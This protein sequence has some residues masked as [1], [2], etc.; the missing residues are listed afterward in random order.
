VQ[1]QLQ[2]AQTLVGLPL[3]QPHEL[4]RAGIRPA[5]LISALPGARHIFD[6]SNGALPCTA[7]DNYSRPA[8]FSALTTDA[9]P[10]R[11]RPSSVKSTLSDLSA[12]SNPNDSPRSFHH[13]P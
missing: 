2:L 4:E 8:I 1:A 6:D 12:K 9:Y 7:S 5:N 3:A 10:G 11:L 13:Q